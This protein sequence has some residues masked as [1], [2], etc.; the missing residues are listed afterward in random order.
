MNIL[1]ISRAWPPV[2]GG[3]ERQNHAVAVELGRLAH[4][5]IV[6]N[7]YGRRALP[8]FLPYALVRA[9]LTLHRYDIVLLGDGVLGLV[10]YCIKRVSRKPVACIVHGLDLTFDN[11]FY[12]KYW[13]RRFLPQLDRLIAVGNETLHM[14][15]ELGIPETRLVFIPN[16][17]SV[18]QVSPACRREDLERFLGRRLKGATLLTLGRLVRRKGVVWFIDEVV[19][20][21]GED[22]TYIIAGDGRERMNIFDAIARNGLGERVICT[23]PVSERDKEL[24]FCTTDLFIQ[25]NI[26]VPGDIEGFGM[27][28]LEAAARGMVVIA[29]ALEGLKDA[30]RDGENGYLVETQNAPMFAARIMQLLDDPAARE[31]FGAQARRYLLENQSWPRI[32]QQY[33]DALCVL[34]PAG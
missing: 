33:L 6:A 21:L 17:V 4:V 31:L 20:R 1:F 24:L 29:S 8:L 32:A 14:G 16:G 25:P 27:V 10:G 13:I 2:I 19:T 34:V 18:P 28:V 30:I 3:I 9:L 26:R 5:D 15:V 12:Q 23:G 22:I 11:R 7:R